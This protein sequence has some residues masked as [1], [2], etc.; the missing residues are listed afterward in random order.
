MAKNVLVDSGFLVALLSQR[1]AHHTW[2]AGQAAN[3]PPPWTTAEAIISEAFHLLGPR[4]GPALSALLH[5]RALLLGFA[6]DAN[7][8]PVLKLLEKYSNVPMSLADACL[9]RMT[10]TQ[11]NPALLTTDGDFLVYR[12]LGRQVIPTVMPS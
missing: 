1:D 12:R 4:G 11:S 7:L 9:V 2:A 10:E 8:D 6:L 5:R 3:F